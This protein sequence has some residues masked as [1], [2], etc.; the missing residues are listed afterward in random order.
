[1]LAVQPHL[2]NGGYVLKAQILFHQKRKRGL[3]KSFV[4][5]RSGYFVIL[6]TRVRSVWWICF[7]WDQ[8]NDKLIIFFDLTPDS[9]NS[10][11]NSQASRFD[12]WKFGDS[13]TESRES[14]WK[15]LL[16]Y[17]W[18]VPYVNPLSCLFRVIFA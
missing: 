6:H 3:Q 4:A 15:W 14:R 8:S 9:Q 1:M 11:I 2:L 17:F 7:L 18:A 5:A 16:T 10:R 12:S 13:R